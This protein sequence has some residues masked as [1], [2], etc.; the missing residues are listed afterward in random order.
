MKNKVQT[1]STMIF[2]N[3]TSDEYVIPIEYQVLEKLGWHT[4]TKL[5]LTVLGNSVL[6]TKV[7]D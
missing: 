2:N 5:N 7:I 6:I 1:C 4:D 3:L